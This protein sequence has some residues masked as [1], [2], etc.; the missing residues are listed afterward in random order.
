MGRII[1]S[2]YDKKVNAK[3][4]QVKSGIKALEKMGYK[5]KIDKDVETMLGSLVDNIYVVDYSGD[6]ICFQKHLVTVQAKE[7]EEI[8]EEEKRAIG[9]GIAKLFSLKPLKAY[10]DDDNNIRYNTSTGTKTDLG[11]YATTKRMLVE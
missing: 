5:I 4:S 1:A 6:R 2:E 7:K 9:K 8:S 10:A 11:L 3:I